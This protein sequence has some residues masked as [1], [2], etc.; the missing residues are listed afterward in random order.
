LEDDF[1]F[2]VSREQFE[3]EITQL[4]NSEVNFDVCMLSYNLQRSNKIVGCNFLLKVTEAQTASAYIVK[5]HYYDV[6]IELYER[7]V[8][9]RIF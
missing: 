8:P 2:L 4:M 6:L 3:D 1:T 9:L 5:E 7:N